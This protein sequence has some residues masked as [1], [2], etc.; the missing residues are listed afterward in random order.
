MKH[1]GGSH[2]YFTLPKGE[3]RPS[4]N[5]IARRFIRHWTNM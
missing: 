1:H 5:Y 3:L 2:G 4:Y